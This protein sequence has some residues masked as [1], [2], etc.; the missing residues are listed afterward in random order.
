MRLNGIAVEKKKKFTVTT[1]SNHQLPIA[2]NEL[3]QQF[4]AQI[5]NEK[6]AADITYIWTRQGWLYLAVVLDGAAT[7]YFLAE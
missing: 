4:S 1:D 2:N 5:P 6:W 3:D 7:V